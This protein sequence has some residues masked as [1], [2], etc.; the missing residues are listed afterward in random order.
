MQGQNATKLP[1]FPRASDK[2]P[3]F[4]KIKQTKFAKPDIRIL[5]ETGT[6]NMTSGGKI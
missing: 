2:C 6:E 3:V 1:E 5:S 4:Y